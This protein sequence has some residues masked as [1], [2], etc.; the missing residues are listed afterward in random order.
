MNR[1]KISAQSSERGGRIAGRL[2]QVAAAASRVIMD[3]LAGL[4]P[5]TPERS[6]AETYNRALPEGSAA[7][8]V[9]A[10]LREMSGGENPK[11]A[12]TTYY[13]RVWNGAA[14][15]KSIVFGRRDAQDARSLINRTIETFGDGIVLQN[16]DEI[17][18]TIAGGEMPQSPFARSCAVDGVYISRGVFIDPDTGN[19]KQVVNIAVSSINA[20]NDPYNKYARRDFFRIADGGEPQLHSWVRRSNGRDF[21]PL[22]FSMR[23]DQVEMNQLFNETMQMLANASQ[24]PVPVQ[25]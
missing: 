9:D 13:N 16:K 17:V 7:G 12:R 3:K 22:P 11:P 25:A 10:L 5:M 8:R 19:E 15:A 4:Q 2:K 24:P 18:P 21:E 1:E 6:A 20:E 23:P 14:T